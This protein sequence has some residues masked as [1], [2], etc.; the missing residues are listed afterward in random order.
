MLDSVVQ[1]QH[2]GKYLRKLVKQPY[3][4]D[5]DED[6]FGV[7]LVGHDTV[8]DGLNYTSRL[9]IDS[10]LGVLFCPTKPEHEKMA[11]RWFVAF[12]ERLHELCGANPEGCVPHLASEMLWDELPQVFRSYFYF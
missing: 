9:R 10:Y 6:Y 3:I 5:I 8:M 7:E 4:L 2:A 11:D 1:G 12:L